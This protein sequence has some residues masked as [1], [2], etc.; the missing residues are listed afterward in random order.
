MHPSTTVPLF[1]NHI[2]LKSGVFNS[3]FMY[4]H[5]RIWATPQKNV[6]P[7][8]GVIKRIALMVYGKKSITRKKKLC[9]GVSEEVTD[10]WVGR[11][12]SYSVAQQKPLAV[13]CL[14]ELG[15]ASSS[16]SLQRAFEW[17]WL[18]KTS[19]CSLPWKVPDAEKVNMIIHSSVHPL[20]HIYHG[21]RVVSDE[22]SKRGDFW[23]LQ[24]RWMG[25][26]ER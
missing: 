8:F 24:G 2:Q 1:H 15:C 10:F 22:I 26:W 3:N 6:H 19:V 23:Y 9:G 18:L 5:R 7:R 20:W 13:S 17:R 16:M 11:V 12:R 25:G 14:V 4:V 21:P